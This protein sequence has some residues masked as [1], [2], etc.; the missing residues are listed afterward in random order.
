MSD[1]RHE[2]YPGIM[3]SAPTVVKNPLNFVYYRREYLNGIAYFLEC[4]EVNEVFLT[5]YSMFSYIYFTYLCL[6]L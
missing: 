2:V 3:K 6:V 4:F 1:E 5:N